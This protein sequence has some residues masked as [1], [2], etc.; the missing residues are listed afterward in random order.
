AIPDRTDHKKEVETEDPMIIYIRGR[1][2][3]ADAKKREKKKR[4]P[5]EGEGSRP[6]RKR[7]K[8]F[9]TQ[10]DSSNA[11][12]RVSSPEP[13][14][15]ADPVGPNM[16]NPSRGAANIAESQ[17]DH[18]TVERT[19]SPARLSA[20][21]GHG[22][23]GSSRDQAYYVPTQDRK[24]RP[25]KEVETEDPTII[26]IRGRKARAD[27]KKREKKKRGPDEG[28]GSRP[29]GKRKKTSATKKDSSNASERVSSPEPIRMADPVGPNM[30]N[31]SRGAANIDDSQ[32]DQSLH[33]FHHD[34]ANHFV[35]D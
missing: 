21:G 14:R 35:H 33:A 25:L 24:D 28:E 1:K 34:P 29:Q 11:S 9:A 19:T 23:E 27:A 5:D 8:T 18:L 26:S 22:D 4:G 15:M 6:Q 32:G 13:I 12:E 2:V 31:P 16:E 17:G 30:E 10:K 7:K 20:Q 3:H